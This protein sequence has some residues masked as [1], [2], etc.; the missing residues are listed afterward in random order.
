MLCVRGCTGVLKKKR[1]SAYERKK[2]VLGVGGISLVSLHWG[3]YSDIR[4]S[5]Y[6]LRNRKEEYLDLCSGLACVVCM[7]GFNLA[8][9]I[10]ASIHAISVRLDVM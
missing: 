8:L 2:C 5:L 1:D 10:L 7:W 6:K 9:G 3:L 4:V